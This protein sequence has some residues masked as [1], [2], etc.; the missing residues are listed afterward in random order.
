M[1]EELQ[2][3]LDRIQKEGVEKA[4][5]EAEAIL[6][7]AREEARGIVR[8]AE[9]Q[10][11]SLRKKAEEDAAAFGER[12]RKSLGQAARDVVLSVGDAVTRVLRD[13]IR[14]EVASAMTRETLQQALTAVVKSYFGKGAGGARI[15]L[16][17][18]PEAVKQVQDYFQ[19]AFAEAL[20][21]GLEIRADEG[22]VSGFKVAVVSDEVEHDFSAEAI[23]EALCQLLRPTLAEIVRAAATDASG[24]GSAAS[25]AGSSG[26]P[27]EA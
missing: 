19:Q 8:E 20:K 17:L 2:S 4:D 27:A 16:L 24:T 21:N 18:P 13:L 11:A 1:T 14:R 25:N 9:T 22:L 23:T 26:D 5:A 6:A 3:L 12:S 7:A 15:D 10:A